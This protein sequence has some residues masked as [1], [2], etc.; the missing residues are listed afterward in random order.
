LREIDVSRL[1]EKLRRDMESVVEPV[2]WALV[3]L[4][5][6]SG[7]APSKLHVQKALFVAS[8]YIDDLREALEFKAYRMGP[9]SEEVED[10]LE[11]AALRGMVVT[12]RDGVVLTERG[13][14]VAELVWQRLSDRDREVLGKT[15]SFL[16]SMSEDELLL[17][18][19]IVYGYSEKSDIINRLLRRRKELAVSMLGKDL[20]SVEL[21]ARIAGMTLKDFISYLREKGVKPYVAE[22]NDIE[23]AEKL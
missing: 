14:A 1:I 2:D 13:R 5:A 19:Y 15:A 4:Y 9:W 3:L 10:A 17:Y 22:A 6:F 12:S 11:I 21:A 23:E 20:I 18:I 16:G 8:R 7:R